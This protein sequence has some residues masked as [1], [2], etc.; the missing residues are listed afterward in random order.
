MQY[1]LEILINKGGG[2]VRDACVRGSPFSARVEC[3]HLPQKD[4][5]ILIKNRQETIIVVITLF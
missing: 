2:G 4:F 1:E 3:E 5:E